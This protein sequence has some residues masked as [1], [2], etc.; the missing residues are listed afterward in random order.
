MSKVSIIVPIYN[1]ENYVK[2]TIESVLRQTEPEIEIILVDDGSTDGSGRICDD[3]ARKDERIRVIHKPNGGLSSARNAG[4]EVASSDYVMFL[5]GD[6]YLKDNA[7]E[8]VYETMLEYPSDFVQFLYRE[9]EEGQEPVVQP[10][11]QSVYWAHTTKELF[12][13]LYSLGGVA[14]SA[15]TKLFRRELVLQIPFEN[16]RHEDEMWCT[17][18]FQRNLAVTYLP[19]E[20]YYY[21]MRNGSIIHS[22]F[23]RK[24]LDIFS[25]SE[26]RINALRKADLDDLMGREYA[27]MFCRLLGL[28]NEARNADDWEAVSELREFFEKQK[29]GIRQYAKLSGKFQA[30]F[31]LMSRNFAAVDIYWMYL[32]MKGDR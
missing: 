5:D 21:V 30:L 8:K 18:A 27:N 31:R 23:N 2:K 13:N 25:V 28:Y 16:I 26:E 24:K 20:I 1:V 15:A 11:T 10:E 12:E 3:F 7:V 9:L 14:A 32:R 17:R 19:E 22:E 6:D 4:A 29:D